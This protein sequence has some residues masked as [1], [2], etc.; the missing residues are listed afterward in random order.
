MKG[1]LDNLVGQIITSNSGK[2]YTLNSIIG[3]GSQ[4]VVFDDVSGERVIKFYYPAESELLDNE[5]LERLKFIQKIEFPANFVVIRDII[6]K[7]YIGY[8]MDK[9]EGLK[10]LNHYLIPDRHKDFLEWYNEGYGLRERLFVGFIIAKAF[11]ELERNNYSYCD[12]SGNNILVSTR[13]KALVRLID[14]DNIYVAGR[15]NASV[16]GTPRYIAPEVVNRQKNPDVLSDNYSLAVI[17][18]EL[19]RVGHPYISDDILDGT[20]EMEEDALAGKYPYVTKDNST[21]MLPEEVVFTDKLKELF[22][23]CFVD[24]KENR[25]CRPSAFEFEKALLEASNNVIRCNSCKAWHYFITEGEDK[26]KCPWCGAESKYNKRLEF[27]DVLYDGNDYKDKSK[28][29]SEK[30]VATYILRNETNNIRDIYV[31]RYEDPRKDSRTIDNYFSVRLEGKTDKFIIYNEFGKDILV[32]YRY[33]RNDYT[34]IPALKALR[35]NAGDEIYFDEP[36]EKKCSVKCHG[37]KYLQIRM[38]RY[39]EVLE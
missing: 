25:I 24:G 1:T 9:V 22:R 28:I 34:K 12:I 36:D 30:Y 2:R 17:L 19:L 26:G 10:T 14:I 6:V 15:G 37:A 18:F 29:I 7:P 3:R 16:L 8:V 13:G 11:R 38:A 32:L 21:N 33:D 4:G 23:K 27:Y 35:L 20:P 31:N 5:R 39:V